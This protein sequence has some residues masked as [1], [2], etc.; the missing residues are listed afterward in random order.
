MF[1]SGKPSSS[2]PRSTTMP[3]RFR[4]N[5]SESNPASE[6]VMI[7]TLEND[8]PRHE[9]LQPPLM[10]EKNAMDEL[11]PG[12]EGGRWPRPSVSRALSATTSPRCKGYA[13]EEVSH[14]LRHK[15]GGL[16]PPWG[17]LLSRPF[18]GGTKAI[19]GDHLVPGGCVFQMHG[20][21][22]LCM[23]KNAPCMF[24]VFGLGG[25]N[26]RKQTQME[27]DKIGGG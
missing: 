27:E 18:L 4:E 12:S 17:E 15:W 26:R 20:P 7:C 9:V 8:E 10:D 11:V 21:P 2:E 13:H 16:T 6:G 24:L 1:G 22:H 3:D 5:A 25:G 14:G 19:T 23:S